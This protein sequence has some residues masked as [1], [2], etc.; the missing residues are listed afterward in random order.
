MVKWKQMRLM[1]AARKGIR[2][3]HSAV[4]RSREDPINMREL[5]IHELNELVCAPNDTR[6][7]HHSSKGDDYDKEAMQELGYE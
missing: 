6:V 4:V 5:S 7:G 1:P 3:N 2:I